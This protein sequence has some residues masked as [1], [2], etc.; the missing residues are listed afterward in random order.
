M[1]TQGSLPLTNPPNA[2]VT[3]SAGGHPP[4]QAVAPGSDS[5]PPCWLGLVVSHRRLF[6]ASQD[7]WMRPPHHSGF[8][9]GHESFVAEDCSGRNIIPVRITFDVDRLPFRA[10]RNNI[11]LAA[12]GPHNEAKLQVV[13]W[14]A[15]LPLYAVSTIQVASD[16]QRTQLLAMADQLSNVSLPNA[17]VTV[18]TFEISSSAAEGAPLQETEEPLLQ[19]P[20]TLNAIQGAMAMA[21]WAVPPMEPWIDLLQCALARNGDGEGV[22]KE[23]AEKTSMLAAHWL[24]MP[25]LVSDR[26]SS[27]NDNAGGQER[28]WRAALHC[29]QWSTV[30]DNPLGPD[31]L[32]E[33]I[34]Q[35]A[36]PDGLNPTVKTWLEQ[37]QQIVSAEATITCDDW[38][39]NG[40][41]LAIQLALLRPDP[42]KFKS[43]NH[44]LLGLLPPGVWWAAAMLCGWRHGYRALDKNFKGESKLQ[45]FLSVSALQSSWPD[46]SSLILPLSQQSSLERAHKNGSYVLMWREQPVIRRPW[47]FRAKWYHAD[48]TNVAGDRAARDL[49]DQLGWLCIKQHFTLTEGRWEI[50]G[51]GCLSIDDEAAEGVELIGNLLKKDHAAWDKLTVKE[52][53]KRCK[54]QGIRLSYK[55]CKKRKNE[56]INDLLKVN[57]ITGKDS[58]HAALLE[59]S[60]PGYLYVKGEVSLRLLSGASVTVEE[61]FDANNFCH[62]LATEPGNITNDPPKASSKDPDD[63]AEPETQMEKAVATQETGI[64]PGLQKES[65]HQQVSKIPGLVYQSEFITEAEEENLLAYIDRAEWSTELQRRVQ[66]YGWRYDYKQRQ[67]DESMHLGPLPQWAQGLAQKLVSED[68]VKDLPDQVI[69]NEYCHDQGISAHIDSERSFTEY[70]ATISLLETWDMVFRQRDSGKKVEIPLERRSVAILSGDARYKWTHEIPKRDSESVV[71][72]DGRYKSEKRGRRISLTF[73]KTCL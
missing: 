53:R 19:L 42:M 72:Q 71:D 10:S 65:F 43:W 36:C 22:A 13:P 39:Q 41:G 45:E 2:G 17:E 21:V 26:L 58:D 28:L 38:Q 54:E 59:T 27:V 12:A 16:A 48:L 5:T 8:R 66:H 64:I 44:A 37:T 15:P 31:A 29:M 32:A 50:V 40:A 61:K 70:V 73:R 46:A 9:L 23:V 52:L 55:G 56:L 34:A 33:L 30:E 69:V 14:P 20:I 4:S 51:K 1:T 25:W 68:W 63:A 7:G 11:E 18:S 62:R 3:C 67:I 47:K 49:A 24:Q 6:D 35:T 57:K 60:R